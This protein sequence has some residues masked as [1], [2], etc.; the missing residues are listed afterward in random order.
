LPL[1]K[2][3]GQEAA[4]ATAAATAAAATAA[5]TA[6]ALG[7][8]A[9]KGSEHSDLLFISLVVVIVEEP[10]ERRCIWP[11]GREGRAAGKSAEDSARDKCVGC[12]GAG[13]ER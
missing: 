1:D 9:L 13:V 6:A 2:L 4:A 3:K 12:G 5:A 8:I 11:S 7:L 10:V